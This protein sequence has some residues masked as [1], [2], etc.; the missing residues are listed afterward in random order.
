MANINAVE[1][2]IITTLTT[3]GTPN[4]RLD[5]T[6]YFGARAENLEY[7]VFCPNCA[8]VEVARESDMFKHKCNCGY[9]VAVEMLRTSPN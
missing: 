4:E 8:R 3:A 2:V 5:T 6:K 9:G 7:E 1:P